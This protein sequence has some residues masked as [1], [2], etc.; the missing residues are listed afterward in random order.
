[1]AQY[2]TEL[3]NVMMDLSGIQVNPLSIQNMAP[4]ILGSWEKIFTPFPIW[5][6]SYREVLCSK[7]LAHYYSYE[8][9]SETPALF[10]FRL[11]RKMQEIMPYYVLLY[12]TLIQDLDL[13]DIDYNM[14]EEYTG[15]EKG[16]TRD[17]NSAE[18]STKSEDQ[19]KKDESARETSE[20]QANATQNSDVAESGESHDSGS[21]N[22]TDKLERNLTTG[23]KSG[24]THSSSTDG[25]DTTKYNSTNTDTYD[26]TDT[27]SLGSGV[28]HS[29]TDTVSHT[30]N[31]ITKSSDTPQGAL[32]NLL[33]DKYLT[34]AQVLV[35]GE[36]INTNYGHVETKTGKD[37]LAQT[38][39]I[40][41]AKTGQ[42]SVTRNT[43]ESGNT[44]S[45][46]DTVEGGSQTHSISSAK[47][48]DRNESRNSKTTQDNTEKRTGS[49][50]NALQSTDE[51]IGN[52]LE[53]AGYTNFGDYQKDNWYVRHTHGHNSSNWINM[54]MQWRD[55]LINIDMMIIEELQSLFM[56]LW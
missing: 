50:E 17:R 5:D 56:G 7:I 39:T 49:R 53:K 37:S 27:T 26:R 13:E 48:A 54:V 25:T 12:K 14:Y 9:G 51:Y 46:S 29:G 23:T 3:Y 36:N 15:N 8:I 40:K 42:D 6:E 32:T 18:R 44:D 38:G 35:H 1:M 24:S 33:A 45:T 11:N 31:D 43:Q 22:T 41:S 2:T 20:N 16:D 30:G 21:E 19:R 28:K 10:I 4:I 47:T 34:E 52:V 55:S